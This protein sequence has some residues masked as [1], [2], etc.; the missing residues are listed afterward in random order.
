MEGRAAFLGAVLSALI[1]SALWLPGARGDTLPVTNGSFESPVVA[2]AA[3]GADGW[4]TDGPVIDPTY[5]V[6]TYTG[7]FYNNPSDPGYIDNALG[8]Q[9]IW[10]GTQTGNEFTQ[11]IAGVTFKAGWS[12]TLSAAV[13]HSYYQPPQATDMLRIALFYLDGASQRQLVAWTDIYND[14]A[15]GLSGNHL[16][17][18]TADGG[19]LGATD[20][21]VGQAVGILLTTFGDIGGYFDLDDVTVAAV[22]EPASLILLALG[23]LGLMASRRKA[24]RRFWAA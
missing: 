9:L 18:F 20:P 5:G 23:G 8:S 12:Y 24:G 6:N 13:A 3:P 17:Y 14:S 16:Y 11:M 19:P 2:F 10:I 15:A 22:P 21:A 4:Q 1:S 7:T